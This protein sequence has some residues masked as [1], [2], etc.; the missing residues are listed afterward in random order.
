MGTEIRRRRSRW[1]A[2]GLAAATAVFVLDTATAD[3]V[4]TLIALLAVPPFVAAVGASRLQTLIVAL[5]SIALTVPAGLIDGIFGK[6]EHVLKAVVVAAVALAAVRIA[7]VRERAELG[8][9]LDLSVANALAESSDPGRGDAAAAR[10]NRRSPRMAS[11][12]AVG[13][14]PGE[15]DAPMRL[16]VAGAHPPRSSSSRTSGGRS[17]SSRAWGC[18]ESCGRA[19][20]RNGSTRSP[21]TTGCRGRARR[22]RPGCTV[23]W[24][25][26]S[27]E[28]RAC[29]EWWSSSRP[30]SAGRTPR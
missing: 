30:R 1:F 5:Y 15:R 13:D 24:R 14:H 12:R 3:R 20:S 22:R 7:A 17:S 11:G 6:F 21:P 9:A 16:D 23:P 4:V 26:R 25:S 19:A 18:R 29:A 8:N 10:G 2:A 28:R 27:S